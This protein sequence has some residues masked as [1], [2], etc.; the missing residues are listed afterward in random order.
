MCKIYIVQLQLLIIISDIC[1][2]YIS[3]R[4]QLNTSANG[5]TSY[6]LNLWCIIPHNKF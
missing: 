4:K 6:A 5:K 1:F 2:L 3:W